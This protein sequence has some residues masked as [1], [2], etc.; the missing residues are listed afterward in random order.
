MASS[1]TSKTETYYNSCRQRKA[2]GG[3]CEGIQVWGSLLVDYVSDKSRS[4]VGSMLGTK[5][6][7]WGW[8]SGGLFVNENYERHHGMG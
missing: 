7:K 3:R 5:V 4:V 6:A 8:T 2:L 1:Q